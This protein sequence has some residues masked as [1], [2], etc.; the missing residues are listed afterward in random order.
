M[1]TGTL[2]STVAEA[3]TVSATV[4]G[5][6]IT[7]TAAVTVNPSAAVLASAANVSSCGNTR[8]EATATLLD[9]IPGSVILIGSGAF[10]DGA[11]TA[12][13]N[14]YSPSWGRHKARTYPAPG[15]QDYQT[16]G[17]TGYFGYFGTQ[18]GDPTKGYYSFDLADWHIILLNTGN[19][20]TVPYGLG[21]AQELWLKA[22]L[23]AN[24]KLCTMAVLHN[25]RFFSSSTAGWFSSSA[26]KFLWNDLYAAGADVV[27]SGRL[28]H[29]ERMAP[30]DG[31]A[32]RDDARGIRQFNVGVGGYSSTL[33]TFIA[34]NSEVV[35][36]AFGVLKLNLAA[37]S[38]TWEFVPI[39]GS[40]FT[41]SGSG[42]CH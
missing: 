31:N 1:A 4:N 16:P 33:P 39:P 36:A 8:D 11:A 29:Y 37:N 6:A 2:S 23:A 17:A 13:A 18:A 26:A 15:N 14:C 21:S 12:Y 35:S 40:T 20:T 34:P 42:T 5:T 28:Y 30:Q 27:L 7:Q 32:V 38:Y 41:D 25:T 24:T 22:D 3:K 19:E 9:A 10:P